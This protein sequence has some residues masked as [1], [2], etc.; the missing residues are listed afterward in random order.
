MLG[1][2]WNAA[3]ALDASVTPSTTTLTPPQLWNTGAVGSYNSVNGYN[4][5]FAG[6]NLTET[7][8]ILF[9]GT[10][11]T[12][13]KLVSSQDIS[14]TAP[15]LTNTAVADVGAYFPDGNFLYAPDAYIYKPVV[16]Y[17]DGD[18]GAES[19]GST[20]TLYGYGLDLTAQGATVTIG[21]VAA[22]VGRN[23]G[24]GDPYPV[25]MISV[26]ATVPAGVRGDADIQF[27]N[28]IGT[29]TV[30][31]G[32]T[33]ATR[34][35]SP[36][37]AA[38]APFQM[39]LD[40]PRNRLLWT[41]TAANQLVVYSI[42]TKAIV[43]TVTL[44]GQPGGL[45]L[46]PDGSKVL[47]VLYG[48]NQLN[49]YDAAS[50][51]LLQQA[52]TPAVSIGLAVSPIF[53]SAVANNKAFLLQTFAGYGDVPVW[54]YDIVS[55]TFAQR[56]DVVASESSLEAASAD[57]GTAFVAGSI[58]TAATDAFAPAFS[59][60][61]SSPHAVSADGATIAEY[62][63]I[64]AQDGTLNNIV[65]LPYEINFEFE[66]NNV[67]GQKLNATGSLEYLPEKDRIRIADVRHG[68][69]LK[70]IMVPDG[71]SDAAFDGLAVD[72]DGQILYLLTNTGVTTFTLASDPLS[73]GEVLVNGS[74]LTV[75]GSGFAP[76]SSL[77]IDDAPVAVNV[78]DSQH[79]TAT[80]PSL[81]SSAHSI[82]V[83]LPSGKSYSL[84]DGLDPLPQ[85]NA[86]FQAEAGSRQNGEQI[87]EAAPANAP[88]P[89]TWGNSRPR[90]RPSDWLH[91]QSRK[92]NALR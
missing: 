74:Q 63:A 51:T 9:D 84:D 81:S 54:E 79:L 83:T 41:D 89:A 64:F 72:P 55:N 80:L 88:N 12:S 92:V 49:V 31:G 10:P 36:L 58:W 6:L 86:G 67:A 52:T 68:K 59:A 66:F 42:S 48:T 40:K 3:G 82:T 23:A 5:S 19:G 62:L 11:A 57:G 27:T 30:P 61:D 45:S 4:T 25:S 15:A 77:R 43:Q 13:V 38:A 76:G 21:G 50:L 65:G 22:T 1:L 14:L 35:D 78:V 16:V 28:G 75:L 24:M 56:N 69:L 39:V 37:P 33:Y 8:E 29:V 47:V 53:I 17:A 18:V 85:V 7:P 32:F 91:A 34:T 44:T 70:T 87:R 46:T 26:Q 20:L 90:R 73:I 71:L 60:S 2:C